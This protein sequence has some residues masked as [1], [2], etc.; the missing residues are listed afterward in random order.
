MKK[1]IYFLLVILVSLSFSC[2]SDDDSNNED[3]SAE[4]YK[5]ELTGSYVLDFCE[6]TSTANIQ[7]EFLEDGTVK[8]T[9]NATGTS[10]ETVSFSENLDGNIFGVKITLPNYSNSTDIGEGFD[11]LN[12]KVIDNNDNS[13]LFEENPSGWLIHCTDICY[14]VIL[15]YDISNS[16]F[17]NEASWL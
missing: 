7:I 17:S 10:E 6:A 14:E 5:V 4:Q 3:S 8:N 16:E 13:V 9:V 2:S 1:T 11:L 15:L 12:F